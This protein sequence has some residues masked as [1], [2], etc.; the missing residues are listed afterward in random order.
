M[1][2]PQNRRGEQH[3]VAAQRDDAAG[4]DLGGADADLADLACDLRL[5]ERHLLAEEPRP[6]AG[7][8]AEEAAD[9]ALRAR[10]QG[11]DIILIRDH[12]IGPA[13]MLSA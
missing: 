5:G 3:Q 1:G 13:A 10:R 9:R 8:I 12:H 7:E 4:R 2:E 6:L 11:A